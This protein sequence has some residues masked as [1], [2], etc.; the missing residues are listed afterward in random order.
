MP[1]CV[2]LSGN[3]LLCDTLVEAG[4]WMASVFCMSF[5][6]YELDPESN[7]CTFYFSCTGCIVPV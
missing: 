5:I 6:R 3:C 2:A 1:V 7:E 4:M